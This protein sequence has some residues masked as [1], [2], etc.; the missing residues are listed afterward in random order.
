M[1]NTRNNR[2]VGGANENN[3]PQDLAQVLAMQA[4]ILQAMQQSLARMQGNQNQ[5]P[6]A[7]PRDKLAEFQRTRPP[8]FSRNIQPLDADDWLK[9][10]TKKLTVAQCSDREKVL[11]ASHLLEGPATEWWDSYEEA[12]EDPQTSPGRSS[13]PAFGL[14]MWHVVP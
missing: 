8:T 9:L 2:D 6:H 3:Q 1:A 4:Q 14:H 11:F 10:V 12:H 7:P 5:Q 13:A